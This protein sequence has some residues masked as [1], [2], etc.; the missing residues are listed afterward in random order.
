MPI[1]SS[2]CPLC[3]SVCTQFFHQDKKRTYRYCS[4]CW[5]VF[6]PSEFHLSVEDEKA[7]YDL[8]ENSLNDVYYRRFLGRLFKPMQ[9]RLPVAAKGLD[10]GCGPAPALANM[11]CEAG[12]K[13]ALYDIF[14]QP[15]L[16]VLGRKYDFVSASEVFEHLAQPGEVI[17]QLWHCLTPGGCLGVM[18]KRWIDYGRF[19]RW[20]YKNDPTHIIFFH[21]NTFIWLAKRLSGFVTVCAD[22]VVILQKTKC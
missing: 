19:T 5:L 14:Y 17:D 11:F 21:L 6:V 8:H 15:D 16:A 10:F 20:H 7:E 2:G 4:V 22:D 12:Y 13:V 3:Q 9:Q 1:E 18:T